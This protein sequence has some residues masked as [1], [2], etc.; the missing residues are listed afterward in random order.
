VP[1]ASLDKGG[2]GGGGTTLA[3]YGPVPIILKTL[4][5]FSSVQATKG[6]QRPLQSMTLGMFQSTRT[7]PA[8][9]GS[10]QMDALWPLV[11]LIHPSNFLRY[12]NSC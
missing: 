6:L 2:G 7:L 11:V 9:H 8:V 12:V 10:A 1:L 3:G 5:D 4:L